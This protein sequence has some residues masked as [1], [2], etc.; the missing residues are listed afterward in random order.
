MTD[1]TIKNIPGYE[2]LYIITPQGNIFSI[3][4][5]RWITSPVG[6]S[7]YKKAILTNKMR[8]RHFPLHRIIALTFIPNPENKP[9]VNHIDGNKLNN[10]IDNLEWCTYSENNKHAFAIGLK[11]PSARKI[12]V[13]CLTTGEV[14]ESMKLAANAYNLKSN[15]ISQCCSG[16]RYHTGKHPKTQQKLVWRKCQL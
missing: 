7:G 6:Q 8:S 13:I 4:S 1:I 9:C 3:A 5:N 2:G 14:F 12:P 15:N 10:N 11:M 16:Q